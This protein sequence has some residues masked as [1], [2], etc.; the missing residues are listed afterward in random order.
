MLPLI[1]CVWGAYAQQN[2]SGARP[3]KKHFPTD[4]VVRHIIAMDDSALLSF[5]PVPLRGRCDGWTAERQRGFVLALRHLRSVA[6]AAR[7]VGLSRET[8]HRL[9]R[10]KG[11]ASF[12]AAWDSALALPPP[13][14]AER[15]SALEGGSCPFCAA[16]ARSPGAADMT[17]AR[18]P[19]SSARRSSGTGWIS[20]DEGKVTPLACLS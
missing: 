4:L 3:S 2:R 16:A 12:A 1:R 7:F 19:P 5:T 9:R 18:S 14:G 15:G 17:I 11:A 20:H 6:D 10:R 8:A 13:G